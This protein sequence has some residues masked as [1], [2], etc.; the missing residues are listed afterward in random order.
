MIKIIITFISIMKSSDISLTLF[1]LL[2]FVLLNVFNILSVGIKKVQ[3]DW[4]LYRCNPIV[5][6]FASVFGH[7]PM[8]NFVH[9]IQSMQT[10]YMDYLLQP[11]HY[12]FSVMTS[13]AETLGTSIDSARAFFNKLR[14]MITE[15]IQSI[16]AV[17]RSLGLI[18]SATGPGTSSLN[19]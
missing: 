18:L 11:L 12:N 10:N 6:P 17:S 5:M 1:I 8:T 16:F 19:N 15:T 3:N 14:N 7:D 2:V 9:C 4:P 13:V